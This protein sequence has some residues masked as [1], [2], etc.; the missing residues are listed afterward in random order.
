MKGDFSRFG[1]DKKKRY[2]AVLMQQGRLQLDADWNEQVQISEHRNTALFRDLV[3]RSG[4]PKGKAMELRLE[5]EKLFLTPGVYYID[6]LF[7]E[8]DEEEEAALPEGGDGEFLYYIETWQRAV[9]AAEDAAL[10]DPAIGVDTTVRLKTEWRLRCERMKEGWKEFF[11]AGKWP[12]AGPGEGDW[13]RPLSTGKLKLKAGLLS[14]RDNRLYRVEVHE[15]E[16]GARFKWSRDNAAVC[17]E[18]KADGTSAYRLKNNSAQQRDAFK[19][20]AWIELCAPGEASGFLLKA[21]LANGVLALTEECPEALRGLE[22]AFI[23]RWD[24]VFGAGEEGNTLSRELGGEMEYEPGGFYRG[25]DYWQLLTRDREVVNWKFGEAKPPEGVAHHFAALGVLRR[26]GKTLSLEPLRVLFDPLTNPSLSTP[27]DVDIGG[28]LTVGGATTIG[29]SGVNSSLAVHGPASVSGAFSA[30]STANIVGNTTLGGVLTVNGTGTSSV[31]GPL[32]LSGNL[33]GTTGSFSVP[34]S[35]MELL[36]L[37]VSPHTLSFE[38]GIADKKTVELFSKANWSASSNAN[39]C[40]LTPASGNGNATPTVNVT[41]NTGAS[42][43]TATLTF[44]SGGQSRTVSVAQPALLSPTVSGFIPSATLHGESLSILG[45]NFHPTPANNVVKMNG[46][47][48]VVAAVTSTQLTV[49]VPKNRACS[50]QITVKVGSKTA[51]SAAAFDYV[52]KATVTT[53]AGSTQGFEDSAGSTQG[54]FCWPRRIA[55]DA[56]GNLYVADHHRIRKVTQAGVVSTIVGSGNQVNDNGGFAPGQGAAARFAGPEGI[57]VDASGNNVYVVD[58][59][60][61]VWR[62]TI[63]QGATAG[64]ANPI[65]GNDNPQFTVV[66]GQGMNARFATPLGITLNAAGTALYVAEWGQCIRMMTLP[67]NRVSTLAGTRDGANKGL[68]GFVDSQAHQTAPNG[69]FNC[70]FGIAI[71]ASGNLYVV[72]RDNHCIRKVTPSGIVTT[73]AGSGK[74]G[75]AD[76]TGAAAQFNSPRC[77]VMDDLGN[78]YVADSR[79]HCIRKVTPQGVVTTIAGGGVSGF[80]DG[81]GTAARFNGPTG[82]A[83]DRRSADLYVADSG[84]H[85]IRKIVLE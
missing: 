70:P 21:Q 8:A 48:A 45:A 42:A 17:A 66:D 59:N 38:S 11:R 30:G 51:T 61:R 83:I 23:R 16:R 29:T 12:E 20:A 67:D 62:V 33:Q 43:R 37:G 64:T 27:H 14:T 24:G 53:F 75:F 9:D 49:T 19:N 55:I 39:W 41:E 63:P 74:A 34:A 28:K 76:G 4:T 69:Q 79:N 52:P 3:G 84:N 73:V 40:T 85:R 81:T 54:R 56:S 82:I 18:V 47:D 57:T 10:V 60:H 58:Y 68:T 65:A 78:F 6:G 46:I 72:E 36:L 77:I 26:S 25:G 7:V 50:G 5:G 1:F 15:S 2:S 32:S 71:D 31:K 13:W 35:P 80:S 44:T 22:R